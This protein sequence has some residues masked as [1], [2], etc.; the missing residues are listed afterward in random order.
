MKSRKLRRAGCVTK[1]T[2]TMDA[3]RMLMGK[4]LYKTGT[5]KTD[6]K[7]EDNI[8][9]DLQVDRVQSRALDFSY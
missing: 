5:W 4:R 3:Y 1:M 7:I 9:V 2:E 6:G 8:N